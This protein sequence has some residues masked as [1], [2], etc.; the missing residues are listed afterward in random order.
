MSDSYDILPIED[1]P[2]QALRFKLVLQRVGYRVRV[3][4]D[5]AEGWRVACAA[6]FTL[7]CAAMLLL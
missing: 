5:R 3:V 6:V 1:G 4:R 2:S 7:H